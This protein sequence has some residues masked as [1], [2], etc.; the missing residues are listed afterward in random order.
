MFKL[1]YEGMLLEPVSLPKRENDPQGTRRPH[2]SRKTGEIV[3]LGGHESVVN[4]EATHLVS[5]GPLGL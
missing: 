1:T 4:V 3:F 5:R 2:T